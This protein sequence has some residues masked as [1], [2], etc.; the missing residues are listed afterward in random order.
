M[1]HLHGRE[2][3]EAYAEPSRKSLRVSS[4]VSAA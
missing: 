2:Q 1:F 4:Y 3:L